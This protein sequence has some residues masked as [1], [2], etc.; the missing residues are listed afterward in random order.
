[1]NL[2][3]SEKELSRFATRAGVNIESCETVTRE[4]RPPHFEVIALM[5]RKPAAPPRKAAKTGSRK[6]TS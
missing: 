5:G 6:A 1:V 3:F 4:R 2:G